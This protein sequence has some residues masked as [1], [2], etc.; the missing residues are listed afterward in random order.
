MT[1]TV[2]PIAKSFVLHQM[3]LLSEIEWK[4]GSPLC[5]LCRGDLGPPICSAVRGALKDARFS[6]E[7]VQLANIKKLELNHRLRS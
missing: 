4:R 5:S 6:P 1:P 2:R 7:E 3:E